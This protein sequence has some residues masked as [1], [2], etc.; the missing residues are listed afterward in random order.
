MELTIKQMEEEFW[1]AKKQ[2]PEKKILS[3]YIVETKKGLIGRT[4]HHNS[5]VKV[6]SVRKI[7]VYAQKDGKLLKMLCDPLTLKHLGFIN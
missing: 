7:K 3:G 6:G 4:Y 2:E 5:P 1:F